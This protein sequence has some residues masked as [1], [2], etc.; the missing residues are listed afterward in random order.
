[1]NYKQ[2]SKFMSLVLRHHPEKIGLHL[3]EH[4]WASVEELISKLNESGAL[5]DFEVLLNVVESNDKKRFAFNDD[6]TMIRAS[7]GHSIAIDLQLK[8]SS[9]PDILY[10]G[11]ATRFLESIMKD[12]LLKRDRQHVHL[13]AIK[14]TALS[15]GNRHGKPIVLEVNAAE[16]VKAGFEFYLSANNVWLV[17]IVLPEFIVAPKY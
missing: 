13:T 4:G 11:T 12:G 6:K 14:E 8:P 1:M 17:E 16:M 7:Q 2:I 9:P 10:H 15:V 5:M 3:D